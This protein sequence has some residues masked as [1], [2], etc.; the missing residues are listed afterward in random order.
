MVT[1]ESHHAYFCFLQ[2]PQISKDLRVRT[3]GLVR[4]IRDWIGSAIPIES[5]GLETNF[6]SLCQGKETCGNAFLT[7]G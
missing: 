5:K 2:T 4:D 7:D 1:R 3:T 6:C